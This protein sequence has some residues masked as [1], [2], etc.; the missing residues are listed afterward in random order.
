MPKIRENGVDTLKGFLILLVVFCHMPASPMFVF[1]T[2]FSYWEPLW[3]KLSDMIPF[4]LYFHMPLFLAASGFFVK[5]F[6]VF[7]LKK[8]T[9]LLLVPYAFLFFVEKVEPLIY[10][11]ISYNEF[12]DSMTTIF[13]GNH[14]LGKTI[15]WFFPALL[16]FNILFSLYKK[17]FSPT[18]L[19]IICGL[20]L[21]VFFNIQQVA[22]WHF[23]GFIPWGFD[24]VFYMFPY[25]LLVDYFYR[26]RHLIGK[27]YLMSW[28]LIILS[29]IVITL[30]EPLKIIS[31]FHFR[32]DL[33]QL[34]VPYTMIGYFAMCSLSIGILLIFLR[35]QKENL[36]AFVGKYTLPIY[37]LHLFILTRFH[38]V[39]YRLSVANDIFQSGLFIFVYSV[40]SFLGTIIL[41]IFISKLLVN[42]STKFKYIGMVNH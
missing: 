38:N 7:F 33:A 4:I 15:L 17:Y 11:H 5:K 25:C 21:I 10:H 20:W 1:A 41:S 42:I 13:I 40:F 9:L 35:I 6:S 22:K 37:V 19:L 36:L 3:D 27:N 24:V 39:L 12:L 30:V 8:R 28:L 29:G 26:Q 2:S 14:P 18:L 32:I 23:L 31:P 16:I 34:S